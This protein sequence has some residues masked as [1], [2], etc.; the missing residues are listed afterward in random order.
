[1]SKTPDTKNVFDIF[2]ENINSNFATIIREVPKY[3]QSI[4]DLQQQYIQTWENTM[5]SMLAIQKEVAIKTGIQANIP[6]EATNTIKE[7][8]NGFNKAYSI[9]NQILQT[10]LD[11]TN[12]NIKTFNDNAKA[13]TD[14]NK[15]IIQSWINVF[16]LRN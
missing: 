7:T 10:S 3:H 12:Q 4:T 9:Q 13:F 15:N 8:N 2:E 5:K 16:T 1:M 6:A 14:L 11:T